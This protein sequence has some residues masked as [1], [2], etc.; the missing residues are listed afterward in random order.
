VL[1]QFEDKCVM[2]IQPYLYREPVG[3]MNDDQS[4]DLS[5]SKTLRAEM[6]TSVKLDVRLKLRYLVPA[7]GTVTRGVG[8][9]Y[10]EHTVIVCRFCTTFNATQ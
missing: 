10:I 3:E 8:M 7:A 4:I 5:I 9:E 1:T 2:P 6:P